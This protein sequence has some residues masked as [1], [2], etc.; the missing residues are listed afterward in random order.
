[1]AFWYFAQSN[2]DI[3][4]VET[5]LGGRWDSTNVVTPVAAAVTSIGIDHTE[6]LGGTLQEIADE[7]AEDLQGW[8]PRGDWGAENRSCAPVGRS[9][10]AEAGATPITLVRDTWRGVVRGAHGRWGRALLPRRP[11]VHRSA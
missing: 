5:G 10:A 1:M 2:V 7:K 6:Y 11:R 4:V 3:A 8:R 9:G